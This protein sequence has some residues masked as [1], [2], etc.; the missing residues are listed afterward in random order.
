MQR[1][2]NSINYTNNSYN[3]LNVLVVYSHVGFPLRNTIKEHLYSFKT[4]FENSNCY[5]FKADSPYR[6]NKLDLIPK[7][8]KKIDFD[9]IVFHY[10]FLASRFES[11][12]KLDNFGNRISFLAKSRAIKIAMPQ[13]E[14]RC[15]QQ[16][17]QFINKF[18]V[19]IISTVSPESEWRKIYEGVN[20]KKIVFH[21][22]LTG[23]LD[24]F[25]VERIQKLGRNISRTK[26]IGYRARKIPPWLG[27]HGFLKTKIGEVFL[28]HKNTDQLSYDV[29]I[30]SND[31][32]IG[33]DWYKF[34]LECK[35]TLGVEG[36]AS[37]LDKDGMIWEQG[38]KLVTQNPKLSFEE[39]ENKCFKGED[40]RLSLYAISP[41][42]LEC[43]ATK[44]CQ[45]LIEGYY[46]GVLKPNVHYIELKRDFSNLEEVISLV[47]NDELRNQITEK[48]Y[49]DIVASNLYTYRKFIFDLQNLVLSMNEKNVKPSQPFLL[50]LNRTS[51]FIGWKYQ[52]Y[53]KKIWPSLWSIYVFI[54]K[55][56]KLM[57]LRSTLK[58][59]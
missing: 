44:T 23:F 43:C 7:Y 51:E 14:Y 16:L 58:R 10:G 32:F 21:K 30:D 52:W 4:Y 38:E 34:L 55:T 42:H 26:D 40:G 54:I 46:D 15:S 48:A 27:R 20:F 53:R 2:K 5:Y 47:K 29:S 35:Y 6:K 36:G 56:L 59:S 18:K 22:T 19:D 37:V 25:S 49:Q 41:R 11:L 50:L 28:N 12:D 57:S 3:K 31:V 33:D 17:V 39:I 45:I 13:D 8:L 9:L 24:E 1:L